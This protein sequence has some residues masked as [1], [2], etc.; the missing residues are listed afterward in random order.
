MLKMLEQ[1]VAHNRKVKKG[2]ENNKVAT[3]GFGPLTKR[4]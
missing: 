4:L 3:S 2:E 1:A